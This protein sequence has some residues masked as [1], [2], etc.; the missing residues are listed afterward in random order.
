MHFTP[1]QAAEHLKESIASYIES[2][3]RISHPL[4]FAE[5]SALL[6]ERG[7][8]AQDPFIEAAPAFAPARRLREL[9]LGDGPNWRIRVARIGLQSLGLNPDEVLKHGIRREVY[10]MPIAGNARTFLAGN[11]E[12]ATFGYMTVD[13][14]SDLALNRWLVPRGE[15]R[16]SYRQFR[17]EH[18]R[19]VPT[20][21]TME[22]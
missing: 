4:V 1:S 10:A 16:P 22:T 13:E 6:R 11:D 8:I 3:Y 19:D 2:Q 14:I 20:P 15:S 21:A 5:R 12:E 7:V 18:L 9:E 17:R